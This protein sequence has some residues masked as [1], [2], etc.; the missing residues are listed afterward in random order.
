MAGYFKLYRDIF[1]SSIWMQPVDLRLFIYL[2]GQARYK[3]EP[4]TKYKTYGIIIKRGQFLRSYRKIRDDL[5]YFENNA[6]KH[7]SLSVIKRSVDRLVEQERIKIQQTKLGTLFTVVNYRQYQDYQENNEELGTDLEQG[8]NGVG[9]PAEQYSKKGK[10][11]ER[12]EKEKRSDSES[13]NTLSEKEEYEPKYG[14]ESIPYKA[15]KYLRGRVLENNKRQPV[16]DPNPE[17]LEDWAIELERLNRLGPKGKRNA[18]YSWEEIRNIMDWCQ[19]DEFWSGNICSAPTFR[20]QITKLENQMK[21]DLN[22]NKKN[23]SKQKSQKRKEFYQKY[24]D[25]EENEGNSGG[26]V[27]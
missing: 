4:N 18:G 5:E 24:K 21:R 16:P 2:I 8:W 7:Y 27:L 25:Q 22:S 17:D 12:R 15:A 19:E 1:E 9:T 26:G 11:G 14:E 10:E 6:V 20:D 13:P 23:N 3:E